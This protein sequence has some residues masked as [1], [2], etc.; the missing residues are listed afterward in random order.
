MAAVEVSDTPENVTTVSFRLA[1]ASSLGDANTNPGLALDQAVRSVNV[2]GIVLGRIIQ[3]TSE[4]YD[5]S[6]DHP[7]DTFLVAREH[8]YIDRNDGDGTQASDPNYGFSQFP[9]ANASSLGLSPNTDT[10][11]PSYPMKILWTNVFRA[12]MCVY[13]IQNLPEATGV[14]LDNGSIRPQPGGMLNKRL[15]VRLDD[16]H[17]LYYSISFISGPTY[18]PPATQAPFRICISGWLYYR[19][20]F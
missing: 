16:F 14:V 11:D 5:G 18:A 20:G 6:N 3:P 10:I 17:N 9:M 8:L 15:K 13:Q 4:L 2:G 1:S 7:E 19:L 12:N